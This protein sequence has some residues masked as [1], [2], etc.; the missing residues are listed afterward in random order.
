MSIDTTDMLMKLA[1]WADELAEEFGETA[2]IVDAMLIVEITHFDHDSVPEDIRH[3]D[4]NE[5][6]YSYVD[7]RVL[8]KR[9]V[10]ARGLVDRINE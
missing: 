8:S 5:S 4:G 1:K 3:E 10:V 9:D 2:E 7:Y 6:G